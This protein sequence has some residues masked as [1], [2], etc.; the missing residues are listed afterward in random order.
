M[1]KDIL[2]FYTLEFTFRKKI[3]ND[4]NDR[5]KIANTDHHLREVPLCRNFKLIL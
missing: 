3:S 5:L 4:K 1:S 2:T